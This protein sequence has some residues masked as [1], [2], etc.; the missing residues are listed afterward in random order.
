V[1]TAAALLIVAFP[2][3]T[4]FAFGLTFA[5]Y[6]AIG[7]MP[8]AARL[9]AHGF[10]IY[11]ALLLVPGAAIALS[12]GARGV[13]ERVELAPAGP[14]AALVAGGAVALGLAQYRLDLGLLVLA[15]RAAARRDAL[16]KVLDG[17]ESALA[18]FRP[19]LVPMIVLSIL[20][21]AAEELLWRGYLFAYLDGVRG[22]G[23]AVALAVC[24]LG[25]GA[26][27]YYFGLRNVAVKAFHG[28]IW[29]TLILVG[30]GLLAAI[31]AH[32]TFE[33]CV[34][35]GLRRAQRSTAFPEAVAHA[36]H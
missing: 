28:A 18:A 8:L 24:S 25:Y 32:V 15:K 29:G 26:V 13:L 11:P 19:P 9:D 3:L 34:A 23:A 16:L 33:L 30:A 6:R 10:W 12:D 35:R 22:W 36:V 2:L 14:A 1:V 21:A 17:R 27:H 7:G 20:V 5:A 31:L 4:A